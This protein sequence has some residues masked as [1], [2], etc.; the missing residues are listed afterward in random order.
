MTDLSSNSSNKGTAKSTKPA[1]T[2]AAA[3]ATGSDSKAA[4]PAEKEKKSASPSNIEI[5]DSHLESMSFL[6][7]YIYTSEVDK[8]NDKNVLH[9]IRTA[10][11]LAFPD[12]K[13]ACIT[14]M[15]RHVSKTTAVPFLIKSYEY[16]DNWLK[17]KCSRYIFE[18]SI[19]LAKHTDYISF[20]KD[21]PKLALELYEGL[22]CNYHTIISDF[23]YFIIKY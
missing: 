12:L 23:V 5:C 18:E 9:L 20:K 10:D 14:Y 6:M 7:N 13:I 3:S 15:Y 21:D 16:K 17:S 11:K 22:Y 8:L 4:K 19:D 1:A 2:A